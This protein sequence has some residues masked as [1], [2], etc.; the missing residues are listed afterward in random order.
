MIKINGKLCAPCSERAFFR[1]PHGRS[2]TC[3][4]LQ[5]SISIAYTFT[6]C[7]LFH[8]HPIL[9]PRFSLSRRPNRRNTSDNFILAYQIG[10]HELLWRVGVLLDDLKRTQHS[11][12][13]CAHS[14]SIFQHSKRTD[15]VSPRG[16]LIS[17]MYVTSDDRGRKNSLFFQSIQCFTFFVFF[18]Q[19]LQMFAHITFDI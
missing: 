13:R 15:F 1:Y 10:K 9:I 14:W 11:R 12:Y 7:R 3:L 18:G 5:T 2:D 19:R 17:S 4:G 16:H 8:I 6:L